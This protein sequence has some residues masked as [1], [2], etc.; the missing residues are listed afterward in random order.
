[1]GFDIMPLRDA[2]KIRGIPNQKVPNEHWVLQTDASP[3]YAD[4]GAPLHVPWG[5]KCDRCGYGFR[6]H[7]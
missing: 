1:M 5:L 7:P 6:L 2:E 3:N 4:V